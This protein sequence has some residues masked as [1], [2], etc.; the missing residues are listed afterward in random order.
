VDRRRGRR[1]CRPVAQS[2]WRTPRRQR[3][4]PGREIKCTPVLLRSRAARSGRRAGQASPAPAQ[5]DGEFSNVGSPQ[6]GELPSNA[7]GTFQ[8]RPPGQVNCRRYPSRCPE[9]ARRPDPGHL[10]RRTTAISPRARVPG[11]DRSRWRSAKKVVGPPRKVP[12]TADGR[13]PRAPKGHVGARK[14]RSAAE[15]CPWGLSQAFGGARRGPCRWRRERS[16]DR[17]RSLRRLTWLLRRS[18]PGFGAAAA[19]ATRGALP[20]PSLGHRARLAG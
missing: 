17:E 14:A 2:A 7:A 3:R 15:G 16:R 20:E 8:E 4:I 18:R 10:G 1:V 13:C 6:A 5:V 19:A 9:K 11:Q 12:A